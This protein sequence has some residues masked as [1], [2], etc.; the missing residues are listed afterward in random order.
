M[1]F[2]ERLFGRDEAKQRHLDRLKE[3]LDA[4]MRPS[5]ALVDS[6]DMTIPEK[7]ARYALFIYGAIGAL[8]SK[9]GLDDTDALAVLVMFLKTTVH[10]NE[11]DVSRLVGI[12][13]S[14]AGEP[15]NRDVIAEG[16]QAMDQW[17]AGEAGT[18]VSRLAGIMKTAVS[19][20]G[21]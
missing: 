13:V 7:R 3:K 10:M 1:G 8:A 19:S 18:A 4:F 16:T 6:R 5:T 2:L 17:L 9:R 11:H 21:R 14:R 20:T 15:A 12:C